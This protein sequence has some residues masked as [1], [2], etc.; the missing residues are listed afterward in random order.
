MDPGQ[1]HRA[2]WLARTYGLARATDLTLVARGAMGEVYRLAT[3]TAPVAAKRLFWTDPAEQDVELEVGF[4]DRCRAAGVAAP[5]SV[6]STAGPLVAE[7]ADGS[8]WR[9]SEWV[10]G[11]VPEASDLAA[12]CWVAEQ[13]ASIHRMA[14]PVGA[15]CLDP[16]YWRSEVDWARLGAR[17]GAAGMPWA[18]ELAERAPDLT[19][20]GRSATDVP[21]GQLVRS[22]CDL[23]VA[24]TLAA[25]DR[26]WLVDWDNVGPAEPWRELGAMLIGYW[27]APA[28]LSAVID[29]YARSGGAE[30]PCDAT[31][32]ATG[33]CV[34]LNFLAEQTGVLL[35]PASEPGARAFARP[36]VTDLLAHVPTWVDLERAAAGV[37]DAA[38]GLR[39]VR[40][41][42]PA[43]RPA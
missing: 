41:S 12:A 5:R 29:A 11:R 18:E 14:E 23:S 16:W 6:R 28:A 22:H 21:V 30:L 4:V 2:E 8:R 42:R 35:D 13:A 19:S 36:V 24:N 25:G 39:P 34:W 1:R 3:A 38:R 17:A 15:A 7:A 40:V 20:L 32:F 10:E 9:V 31:L 43:A 26:R 27:Q 37:P 33:V